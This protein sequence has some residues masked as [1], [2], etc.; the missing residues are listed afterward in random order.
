[1]CVCVSWISLFLFFLQATWFRNE[2]WRL[3]NYD[4][5]M[6]INTLTEFDN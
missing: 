2:S 6:K 1:L 3:G 4:L 5:D